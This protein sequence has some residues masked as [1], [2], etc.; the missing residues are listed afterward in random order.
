MKALDILEESGFEAYCVGGCVRDAMLGKTPDDWDVCTNALPEQMKELF[1]GFH[2]VETGL[3]HGTLTVIIDRNPVEITTYRTDGGYENHRKP[4]QVEFIRSLSQDLSRRDFTVNAMCYNPSVG[5]VD[6]FGGAEDLKNKI[7]RCV[8]DAPKRFDEDALRIL[9]AVRFASALGF[10]ID[11]DTKKAIL[12]KKEL[13]KFISAE[14][15]FSE[16]KKLLCGKNCVNILMDFREVIAVFIPEISPC[17][18]FLQNNPH[19]IYDVWEH[20]CRSVGYCR[21]EP[22]IRLAMLLHDIGKPLLATVDENGVSHFKKHQFKSADMAVEILKRLKCDA[23]SVSYIHNLIREHDNRIL[24]DKKAVKRFISRYSFEFFM[25][26]LEVRRA[27][28]YAQSDYLKAEKLKTLDR[29]AVIAI[30][31]EESNACLKI[32]DMVC[33]GREMMALGLEGR[34]IGEAL[35]YALEGIISEEIT[36]DRNEIISY[37]KERFM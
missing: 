3:K 9:R 36:N 12:E 25:D 14:R 27:D 26:Y 22:V 10:E 20:I 5:L 2:T 32:T 8:G 37:I 11:K 35:Q 16:L 15:I 7:I 31:A 33:G 1:S 24:E 19:H 34:Q 13:L 23:A 29:L 30:E 18:D 21:P 28:T 4:R 17:F 6:M